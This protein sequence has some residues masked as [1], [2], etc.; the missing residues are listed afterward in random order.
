MNFAE[1]GNSE[2]EIKKRTRG[3]RT[4]FLTIVSRDIDSGQNLKRRLTR[5][6]PRGGRHKV[7][8]ASREVF[9]TGVIETAHPTLRPLPELSGGEWNILGEIY[10][11]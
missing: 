7:F 8:G 2:K 11:E 10:T 3:T 6:K 4:C 9:L 1:K 5:L